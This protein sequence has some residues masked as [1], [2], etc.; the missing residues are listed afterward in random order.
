MAPGDVFN[1]PSN[2]APVLETDADGMLCFGEERA[3]FSRFDRSYIA[4]AAK[5]F[6]EGRD[7]ALVYPSPP[8]HVQIPI[9]LAVGFQSR[10]TAPILFVSNR[11]G[12]RDQYFELG[13]GEKHGLKDGISPTPLGDVTAPI[14]KTGDGSS[15]SYI[16]NHK[17]RH[18][19]PK[20]PETVAIVHTTFGKKITTTL[21][22]DLDLSGFVLDFTTGLLDDEATQEAYRTLAEE[23]DI[24][25]IMVFDSPNHPYL[26]TLES[27]NGDDVLFWGW[28]TSALESAPQQLLEPVTD[29]THHTGNASSDGGTVQSPFTDSVRSLENIRNGINRSIVDI[30]YDDLETAARR[31]YERLSSASSFPKDTPDSY[32]SASRQAITNGYF[33]YMYFDTLPISVE[34]H[35]SLSSLD[36]TQ[37]WG[38]AATLQSK[39]NRLRDQASQL[40]RDAPGSGGI[41][42]EA[43]D[44]FDAMVDLLTEHNPKA[45]AIVEQIRDVREEG[46]TVCVFTATRKQESLLRS[47]VAEKTEFGRDDDLTENIF[48]HSLYSPHTVPPV[49]VAVF[50]GVPTKSHYPVVQTGAVSEQRFLTYTWDTGRLESRLSD[51]V[52]TAEWRVGSGVQHHTARQLGLKTDS[53]TEYVDLD[54]PRPPQPREYFS[55]ERDGATETSLN[56]DVP[57][58]RS[59]VRSL[60]EDERVGSSP[61][62]TG[63]DLNIDLGSLAPEQNADG[64]ARN[65]N[66]EL[67]YDDG[68]DRETIGGGRTNTDRDK[69]GEVRA[70][71]IEL[72]AGNVLYEEPRGLVWTLDS[73]DGSVN[74]MRRSA[75]SLSPGDQVILIEDDS[76]RDVFEHVVEKIHT[77]CRGQFRENLVMLDIWNS[78]LDQIVDYWSEMQEQLNQDPTQPDVEMGRREMAEIITEELQMYADE[79]DAP[80]VLREPQTIHN[81]LT[82]ETIGPSN[83]ETIQALGAVHEIES[84]QNHHLEIHRGLESIRRLHMQVGR[85][86]EQIIFSSR[87]EDSDEWILKEAGLRVGDVQDATVVEQV[88]AVSKNTV[89]VPESKIGRLR[90]RD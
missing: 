68:L 33:L 43:C 34:F 78:A 2:V 54:D 59:G 81:Y 35:D 55:E 69:D 77:E 41:L 30:A 13:M 80:E 66:R 44:A 61:T 1:V 24:P 3:G 76:R 25:R 89:T 82:R 45:D 71:E 4:V 28:T 65:W 79:F 7:V 84:L 63:D 6:A 67:E 60:P 90:R 16:T 32:S 47:F 11:S 38:T 22:P 21:S 26:E 70:L 9:L 46:D 37:S 52:E 18:W 51:I 83:P 5:A 73:T 74:R 42:E 12:I 20:K 75:A 29:T 14:V 85:K 8:T 31:S 57:T 15:L 40:D 58:T 27:R 88:V 10:S 49:D 87:S 72:S 50:P 23:L 48:F 36:D 86:L 64:D 53:L 56:L 17:P 19:D 62:L 39:V